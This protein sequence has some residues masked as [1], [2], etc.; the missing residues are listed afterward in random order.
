MI[1]KMKLRKLYENWPRRT[2][3]RPNSVREGSMGVL[4]NKKRTSC[5]ANLIGYE[6]IMSSPEQQE[7]GRNTHYTF[8]KLTIDG[9]QRLHF[10][11]C[12]CR[13]SVPRRMRI[14][15]S[16]WPPLQLFSCLISLRSPHGQAALISTALLRLRESQSYEQLQ[17]SLGHPL[18]NSSNQRACVTF[19]PVTPF[20]TST[21]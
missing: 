5:L 13:S 8:F 12:L 2:A 6:G 9:R 17:W 11:L 20:A 15:K 3:L 16:S 19:I 1:Q 14:M 7:Q 4:F 21:M 18:L 10:Y